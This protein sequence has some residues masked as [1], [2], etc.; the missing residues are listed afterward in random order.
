MPKDGTEGFRIN[1]NNRLCRGSELQLISCSNSYFL[2]CP[3]AVLE[4]VGSNPCRDMS[5]SGALVEDRD[6]LGQ[7]AP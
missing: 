4:V 2:D 5:V 7:V 6:D 1:S 3:L